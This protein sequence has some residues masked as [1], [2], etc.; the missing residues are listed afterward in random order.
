MQG[1]GEHRTAAREQ[2]F[3]VGLLYFLNTYIKM[4][5]GQENLKHLSLM[6]WYRFVLSNVFKSVL[7]LFM[8]LA[9]ILYPVSRDSSIYLLV[10]LNEI[11]F[12]SFI[13]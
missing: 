13:L 4:K 10:E 12:L 7:N 9:Y 1:L 3:T 6:I 2:V 11:E 5:N 8:Y